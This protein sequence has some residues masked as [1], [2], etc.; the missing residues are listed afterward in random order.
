MRFLHPL[1]PA[2]RARCIE[3][4]FLILSIIFLA[5]SKIW[6]SPAHRKSQS[7]LRNVEYDPV[8]HNA[9]SPGS[10][11]TSGMAWMKRRAIRQLIVIALIVFCIALSLSGQAVAPQR[12]FGRYRQYC[13][14]DEQ[15]LPA[16]TANAIARTRDGYLWIGTSEGLA[17]FD[18]VRFT[19]FD[20]TA[21]GSQSFAGVSALLEDRSGNLWI[22]TLGAGLVRYANGRFTVFSEGLVGDF[23]RAL[24]EDRAGNLWVGTDNA[25][26][27][28]FRDGRVVQTYPPSS[29]TGNRISAVLEDAEGTLWLGTSDGLARIS[30]GDLRLYAPQNPMARYEVRSLATDSAGAIWMG[31]ARHGILRLW[32]GRIEQLS[33]GGLTSARVMSLLVAS[34]GALWMGPFG[35]GIVR[36]KDG[37]LAS[38]SIRDGFPDNDVAAIY[39][40][41]EG[42]MWIGTY[43]DGL[44]QLKEAPFDVYTSKDGLA[45]DVARSIVETSDGAIW[46]LTSRGITRFED[47]TFATFGARSGQEGGSF[48]ELAIYQEGTAWIGTRVNLL[49][50]RNGRFQV[51]KAEPFS[52]GVV[53]LLADHSGKL[54]VATAHGELCRYSGGKCTMYSVR[55]GLANGDIKGLYEDKQGNIWIATLGGISRFDNGHFATWTAKDGLASNLALGFFEDPQGGMWIA[56]QGGGLCRFKNGQF[57]TVTTR[58]GLYDNLAFYMIADHLG[59]LWM[60]SNRGIYRASLK[61]LNDC[62]DGRRHWVT[63]ISY[64]VADGMLTR[65]CNGGTACRTRDG[66]LWFPTSKGVVAVNPVISSGERPRVILEKVA[67]DGQA[68]PT[69]SPVLVQP[70]QIDLDFAYTGISWNRPQ[71]VVFKFQL[72][73]LDRDWIDSG[74][75][76]EAHYSRL[77]PGTYT[78]RVIAQNGAGVWN[79]DG[80]R[81]QVIV[82]APFYRTGWFQALTAILFSSLL[83]VAWKW[84]V[85]QLERAQFVQQAFSRQ[86]IA[87]QESERKRIAA[88]LHDSL[89]QRLVLIKNLALIFLQK[90]ST[91]GT[92]RNEVADI[93]SEASLAMAEMREISYNLRPYQ[94]DRIG[95]T[96]AVQALIR[97][98]SDSVS[99]EFTAEIAEIDNF[100]PKDHEISFYR[101]LQESLSN[102]VKHSHARKVHIVLTREGQCLRLTIRDNGKGFAP[103]AVRPAVGSGGFGLIGISERAQLIGGTSRIESAPGRGTTVS[104]EVDLKKVPHA[105]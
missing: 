61:E 37:V 9:R 86:L 13:W 38:H 95:L 29:P 45:D 36:W 102:I 16:N 49:Q 59:N 4:F 78:F 58:N 17:R 74:K 51:N 67:I 18:G 26:L 80:Q 57:A 83:W 84:R 32:N 34:D 3:R 88:E 47:G 60:G 65:E 1:V 90:D 33:K 5:W 10:Q 46:F 31:T 105:S 8:S 11:A 44:C 19:S 97:K 63:S 96:K 66:K 7:P 101:I 43:N 28:R 82:Q 55:D 15:G 79:M 20:Q 62:A 73:G 42:S 6:T 48:Q 70:G 50:F 93:S 75:S 30:N 54:W 104:I 71:E 92:T 103:E 56:T 22:G 53:A 41:P 40:D 77:P 2:A 25:G 94:L 21:M 87:L 12:V 99:I 27:K 69:S 100:L 24:V 91:N 52:H 64:G 39:Q 81:V 89:G 72:A 85:F 35:R 14:N 68:V 76:R 98:T 23:I